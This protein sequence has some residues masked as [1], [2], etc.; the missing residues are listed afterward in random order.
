MS[1]TSHIKVELVGEL[2]NDDHKRVVSLRIETAIP[3][4]GDIMLGD[5]SSNGIDTIRFKVPLEVYTYEKIYYVEDDQIINEK[6]EKIVVNEINFVKFTDEKEK[7]NVVCSDTFERAIEIY[8]GNDG[9]IFDELRDVE[10]DSTIEYEI[11][12]SCKRCR[13]D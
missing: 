1:F 6:I 12:K 9:D 11:I 13:C 8:N 10:W 3:I 4:P 5:I 2:E 7:F